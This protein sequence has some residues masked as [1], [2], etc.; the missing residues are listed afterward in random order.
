LGEGESLSE[1][2]SLGEGGKAAKPAVVSTLL[3]VF[4]V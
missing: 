2:G 4:T 3:D 1:V